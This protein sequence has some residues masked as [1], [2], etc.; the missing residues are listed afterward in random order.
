[1]NRELSPVDCSTEMSL[2]ILLVHL[3]LLLRVS[4]ILWLL[5]YVTSEGKCKIHFWMYGR[6]VTYKFVNFLVFYVE[7]YVC[8]TVAVTAAYNCMVAC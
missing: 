5:F 2:V 1:M 4:E 6:L 3:Y 8:C 7:Q